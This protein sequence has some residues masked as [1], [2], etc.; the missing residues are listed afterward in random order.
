[1]GFKAGLIS[2]TVIGYLIATKVDPA[3][4][5]RIQAQ[6]TDRITQLRDDPRVNDLVDSVK[7]VATEV[8]DAVD[9]TVDEQADNAADMVDDM[10][11]GHPRP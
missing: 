4:R 2:G 5:D 3:T 11:D 9:R 1:M 10:A 7:T 6:V 8:V